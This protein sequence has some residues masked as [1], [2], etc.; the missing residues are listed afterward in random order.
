MSDFEKLAEKLGVKFNNLD[1]LKQ[2]LTH[3]SYLNEHRS[4]KLDHNE[5]LEFLGDAVLELVVT[6]YL[7]NNFPN[8]EGELTNWRAALVNGE[9]LAKISKRLGVE[10]YLLMSKGESK[11]TGKARTYLLANAF[12]S[13]TGAIYLD[14]EK[15]GFSEA[16]KFI[17]KNVISE[18][19]EILENKSYMDPKSRFQEMAQEKVG[20]TPSYRVL[21]ESGPDHDK[22]FKVGVFLKDE[23]VAEGEGFSK[24]EAQRKA[25]EIGLKAKGW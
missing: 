16:E 14:Q 25:A 23:L 13:I 4:Y 6:K 7:Y 18:L 3:R 5:R 22:K 19:P 21:F 12:E 10:E 2:A 24:Q 11:D 20:V 15:N 1:L 17:L 8:P 9:M